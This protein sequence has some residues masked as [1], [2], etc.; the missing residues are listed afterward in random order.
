M[1]LD[2]LFEDL[3]LDGAFDHATFLKE[4]D[5]V[6]WSKIPHIKTIPERAEF[7]FELAMAKKS[8]F[9]ERKVTAA[10]IEAVVEACKKVNRWNFVKVSVLPC[11]ACVPHIYSP[12][13]HA[14][15]SLLI[16]THIMSSDS[17]FL[18]VYVSLNSLH[19]TS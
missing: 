19:L 2:H 3:Y 9:F 15:T 17:S 1:V 16:A 14:H 18:C 11:S 12:Y 6:P 5:L 8:Q 7:D 13:C 4:F 10:T